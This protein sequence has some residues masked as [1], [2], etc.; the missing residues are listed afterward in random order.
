MNRCTAP[1]E[2]PSPQQLAVVVGALNQ[3]HHL[4]MSCLRDGLEDA[5]GASQFGYKFL[6]PDPIFWL[7]K[8][9]PENYIWK[10]I[11]DSRLDLT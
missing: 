2:T 7:E 4:A 3:G 10:V 8:T 9:T 5:L 6:D 11:P 1:Y